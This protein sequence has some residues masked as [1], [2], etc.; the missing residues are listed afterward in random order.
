MAQNPL[1]NQNLGVIQGTPLKKEYQEMLSNYLLVQ[2]ERA[3]EKCLARQRDIKSQ[4]DFRGWQET[5]RRKFLQLI[6]GLPGERT[7]LNARVVGQ[8]EREGY[9]TR[10]VVFESLPGFFVT[11][12]LY[13]PNTG[14]AP[15]PAVLSPCG[16]S[17]NGKA[18][19]EYQ[20]L[21]IGLAKRG[22]AVLSYDPL[23]QGERYQ[24]WDLVTHRR[25]FEFNEH[26]MAGIQ[27]YLL[28]QN[29]AR[30]RI[31]DGL[32]ALDYL[33]G[34]REVDRERIACTGNSGGGTLTTYISMLDPR[35]KVASVV[36]FI[37][38]LSKKIEARTKDAEA[39]PEQ[40]IQG[41][42]AA[43]IDHTELVGMIAPRP[44]LVG[45]ATRDFFPVEGTRKTFSQLEQIY[46][47]LGVP[48][49]VK[50]V[51]FDHEHKYSQPLREA[52]YSWF[53]RWLKGKE[54]EAHEPEIVTE[55]DSTLQCTVTGQVV[56]SLGGKRVQ[57]F[58][59]A[60]AE[61]LTAKLEARRQEPAFRGNLAVKLR[62][63]LGL[64]SIPL[65]PR[66]R[67]LGEAELIGSTV[68]KILLETEPGIV[69][70]TRVIRSNKSVGRLP[71]VIYLRDRGGERDSVGFFEE[72]VRK[73]GIV[74]VA[75]VRGFGETKSPRN[76]PDP[77][78]NYFDP[79]DGMDADFTY[80]AFSLGRPLLGM[81]VWDAL[82]VVEYLRSRPEVDSN[83]IT[84]VG[85][86]WAG[87]A[88]LFTSALD[89]RISGTAVEQVPVS[90]AEIARSEV[91]AQ[92]VSLMLPGVL[93]DFDLED[94]L[95]AI[96]PRPL[97]VLNPTDA[98][99]RKMALD[100]ARQSLDPVRQRY[101]SAK[102]LSALEIRVQAV[103][104]EA[105]EALKGW[106]LTH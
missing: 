31:W 68:E 50:M 21:Y 33:A 70:P 87:L 85:R 95:G 39:D 105:L 62:Q 101:E 76:L 6:G 42:L 51:E 84:L 57:D 80:A 36:T 94:V 65:G 22:Y 100:Q 46:K 35:I 63:R 91:Y 52:T 92:P 41:L 69:A 28:G 16:H 43:G 1:R 98:L 38:T 12:N 74:A 64:P 71:A 9:V 106:I 53:D 88:A 93:Q 78:V 83:R 3:A 19:A 104:T 29:L 75:D 44:V 49:K 4:A 72:L 90:Y 23:G 37:T 15:H 60:E 8:I 67:N 73:G 103:E 81:R 55:K 99:T 34:L 102:A 27:Q 13:V 7:P 77:R 2:A 32:R 24:Y 17:E 45:A 61:R 82:Q 26:G 56:T 20:R 30:N 54:E 25:R 48:E 18:F 79:R 97:L 59:R 96:S 47:T 5:N 58:N 14:K 10:K 89:L 11:A 66:V 40:D 86:G